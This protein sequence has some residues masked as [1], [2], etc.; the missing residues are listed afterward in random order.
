MIIKLLFKTA[1]LLVFVSL[2]FLFGKAVYAD[3]IS[4]RLIVY[5][6]EDDT[7]ADDENLIAGYEDVYILQ[8]DTSEEAEEAITYYN[9]SSAIAELDTSVNI[10]EGTSYSSS[11]PEMVMTEE[12]NPLTRLE[13]L[14]DTAD[15]QLQEYFDIALID[16]GCSTGGNVKEAVS[17]TGDL[18]GDDNGHG[19]K[20]AE[21]IKAVFPSFVLESGDIFA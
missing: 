1:P 12:D 7:V 14:V 4:C 17:V 16:T 11:D 15:L 19:N 20:M 21:Y 6:Q 13:E 3:D 18:P 5:S 9:D 8:Y 2:M 10:A